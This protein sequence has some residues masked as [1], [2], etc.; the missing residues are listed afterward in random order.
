VEQK[1]RDNNMREVWDDGIWIRQITITSSTGLTSAQPPS[2][3]PSLRL[4]SMLF[5]YF[6]TL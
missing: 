4:P 6:L 5:L 1:L 2:L 3:Q